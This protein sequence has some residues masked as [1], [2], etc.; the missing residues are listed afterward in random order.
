MA[1]AQRAAAEW[2]GP[3][4]LLVPQE[5]G[6]SRHRPGRGDRHQLARRP[7]RSF[8]FQFNV[9]GCRAHR[10]HRRRQAA[11][12]GGLIMAFRSQDLSAL[13]YANGFTLWHYRTADAATDVDTAGYF[14]TANCMLRVGDFILTNVGVGGTAGYGLVAVVT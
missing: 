3:Y 11:L 7:C 13:T 2:R 9:A 10:R 14:N 5:R 12:Q 8:R 4:L 1:P 6:G